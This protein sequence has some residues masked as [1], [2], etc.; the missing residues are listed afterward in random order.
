VEVKQPYF[1]DV[2]QG[3]FET[4]RISLIDGRDFRAGDQ[5]PRLASAQPL[6]GVGVVNEAFARAF[7]DGTNPVGRSVDVRQGKDVAATME[8]IGLVRDAAYR[9]LREAIAPTVYVPMQQ[10]EHSTL[11]VRTAGDPLAFAAAVRHEVIRARPEMRVSMTQTQNDF[12]RWHLIRERLLATLSLFFAGVALVLAAMGLYGVLNYSVARQRREIGIRMALGARARHVVKRISADIVTMI[13]VGS[14]VG[15]AG[16]LASARFIEALLYEVK[17]TDTGMVVAP[18]V[19]LAAAA[20]LAGLPPAMRAA[21][22]DPA[23]T[24]RSD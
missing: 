19:T 16:G 9:D 23:E 18:I 5:P 15:M 11:F 14:A 20:F 17:A 1:L 8:I 24:L 3:F 13:C 21:R 10:R 2:S 7:F 12:V 4:M 22:I 6:P